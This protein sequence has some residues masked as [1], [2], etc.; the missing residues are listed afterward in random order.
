GQ[1]D[2]NLETP[3]TLIYM[4]L[5][6]F[7]P[8]ADE[9]ALTMPQIQAPSKIGKPMSANVR[10][11]PTI[12]VI[13]ITTPTRTLPARMEPSPGTRKDSRTLIAGFLA[14]GRGRAAAVF[15]P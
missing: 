13:R 15:L 9:W 2:R 8:T 4:A 12:Y 11:Q 10:I 3:N 6:R 7:H 14:I 5:R 1:R